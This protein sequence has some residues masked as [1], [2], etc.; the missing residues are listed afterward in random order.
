[1]AST[2]EEYDPLIWKRARVQEL[3]ESCIT[4]RGDDDQD[5]VY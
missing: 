4:T 2:G 1:M 3:Y 5:L